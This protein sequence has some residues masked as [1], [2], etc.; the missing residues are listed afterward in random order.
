MNRHARDRVGWDFLTNVAE[1][2]PEVWDVMADEVLS[3]ATTGDEL[4]AQITEKYGTD[5]VLVSS[6]AYD[7]D[8]K[9]LPKYRAVYIRKIPESTLQTTS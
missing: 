6:F 4:I 2:Y 7:R 1:H 3:E 9:A 8:G 5:S